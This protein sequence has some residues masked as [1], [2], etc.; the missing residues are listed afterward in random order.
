M[1]LKNRIIFPSVCTFFA[2]QDGS[3]DDQMFAFIKARAAGGAAAL[4]IGGSPHGKPGPGRPAISD[5]K[6]MARWQE[7]ADMVHSY[8]A[9]LFCQLHP[10]KIQAGRG[11]DVLAIDDYSHE[12]IHQLVESY[13]AGAKRCMDHGVDAVEIHGGHAHEVAQFMSPY[14]NKR[15]DEYGGNWK[16]RVRFS[17]E[18]VS[19]IKEK[20]GKDFPVIFCISGSEMT[21]GGREIYETALMAQEIVKAGADV[22]HVSCGMPLS[23]HYS[24]APMDVPDC[25]NVENARIV[26]EA[27]DVPIIAVDKIPTV[28]Q[29]NEVIESGDAD[30]VAMARPL[31][32][33]PELVNKY[34]GINP[35]PPRLCIACDQGCR[36]DKRYKAIRC[37][38]NPFL[39][40]EA[41]LHMTE[42]SDEL[43][44]KK[45]M[46]VGAGPAG[47]EAA[48]EMVC[49]GLCPVIIDK[50]EKAGGLMNIAD[51]PPFKTNLDRITDY[52]VKFLEQKGVK[53][54]LGETVDEALLEAE[55]PDILFVATG[56]TPIVPRIPGADGASVYIADDVLAGTEVPGERVAVIGAGLV[57]A[58][59]AE[60]LAERGKKVEMFDFIDN[61]AQDFN[62]AGRYFLMKYLN[63]YDV[64]RHMKCK[65]TEIRLPEIVMEQEGEARILSGFDA[66][67][68]AV[69]RRRQ[70]A[71]ADLAREK[72][73][74]MDVHVI[75]DA[76]DNEMTA[77]EAI[78]SAALEVAAL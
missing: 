15:T 39:G 13:A 4:T 22:I 8:G 70:N 62:K 60:Y 66:V 25:F 72:F 17:C 52:R 43:K 68:M 29:A 31:L 1:E 54:R 44:A 30:L 50:N 73:P 18:I 26:K 10:A 7:T 34:M 42:A 56:S 20:C 46:I 35:E 61:V 6:F 38:Q 78:A 67:V 24:C 63:D 74:A 48:V 28:E 59:T 75:G 21:E 2:G 41:C 45:I 19:A 40:R 36:D 55:K 27:V 49:R 71:L 76:G 57:G 65:I 11:S 77:I 3:I 69:G 47:L 12:L 33:D 58:E 23:D 5:E 64:K 51:K 14:Y 37:M 16:K 53:I 9:K 32:S